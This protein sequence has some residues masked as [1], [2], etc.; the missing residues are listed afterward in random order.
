MRD[1]Q[2]ARVYR[3]EGRLAFDLVGMLELDALAGTLRRDFD[4]PFRLRFEPG[5]SR[6]AASLP[7][8]WI[9][10]GDTRHTRHD[11]LHEFAHLLAE[12][13]HEGQNHGP[14]WVAVY[15]ELVRRYLGPA[16]ADALLDA[17]DL[18]GVQWL[19]PSALIGR[20]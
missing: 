4:M 19:A 16:P 5:V 9:V 20:P 6:A 3:A 8:A 14:L 2:R 7:G 12:R 10:L 18:E 11:L 13:G 15:L 1:F 17:L